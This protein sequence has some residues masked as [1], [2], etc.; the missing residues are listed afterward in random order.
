MWLISL[1]MQVFH[2]SDTLC[3]KLK[4]AYDYK[5]SL[6]SNYLSSKATTSKKTSVLDWSRLLCI[7]K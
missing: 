4:T 2:S 7:M 5:L 6:R 3:T 1:P